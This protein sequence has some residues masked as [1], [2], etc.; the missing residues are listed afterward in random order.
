M[1]RI[2]NETLTVLALAFLVAFSWPAF[3]TEI[4]S[5]TQRILD[6]IQWISWIAFTIDL[7][8]GFIW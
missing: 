1:K 6:Y 2:W 3:V 8:I 7:L 4:D 5:Q